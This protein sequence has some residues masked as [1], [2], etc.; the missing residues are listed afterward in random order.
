MLKEAFYSF[1]IENKFLDRCRSFM[2]QFGNSWP[3]LDEMT[4]SMTP[5]RKR[6]P[7]A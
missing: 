6:K 3:S 7:A 4:S 1:F 5:P 2:G